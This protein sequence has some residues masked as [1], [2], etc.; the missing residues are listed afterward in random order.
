MQRA[1]LK[2]ASYKQGSHKHMKEPEDVHVAV[3]K[4]Y[5][6]DGVNES[7]CNMCLMVSDKFHD[8]VMSFAYR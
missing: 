4:I 6:F 5:K 1:R 8:G 3:V 7:N 2:H